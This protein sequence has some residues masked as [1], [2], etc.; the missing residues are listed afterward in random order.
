MIGGSLPRWAH[1]RRSIS[2]RSCNH[3]EL[4]NRPRG[5][6]HLIG[7]RA[8]ANVL[9]EVDPP[10]DSVRIHQ[11]FSGTRNVNSL[12]TSADVQ[13]II[14]ANHFGSRIG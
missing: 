10:D 1:S 11:E 8:H 3:F 9:G 14:A 5:G 12:G 7:A 6:E 13:Q 4:L 2:L